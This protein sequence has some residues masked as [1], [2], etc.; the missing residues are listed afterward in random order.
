MEEYGIKIDKLVNCG[1][2]AEKNPLVMQIYSDILNRPMEIAKSAQTVASGAA[3]V[4]GFVGIGKNEHFQSIEDIQ[5]RVCKVKEKVFIPTPEAVEVYAN[6]YGL[7]K[8]IHDGFGQ[9]EQ[10]VNLFDVMKKLIEIKKSA[11]GNT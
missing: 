6:I 1:G 2:I 7:Y 8:K 4:G 9:E 10:D 5:S 11:I 3:I